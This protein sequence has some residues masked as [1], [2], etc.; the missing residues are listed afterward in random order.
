M[1]QGLLWK[2]S[3]YSYYS[4]SFSATSIVYQDTNILFINGVVFI[5]RLGLLAV[6]SIGKGVM[7]AFGLIRRSL[8]APVFICICILLFF[9]RSTIPDSLQL[10]S[11]PG[12][13]SEKHIT[14]SDTN[15]T[16]NMVK[17]NTT[18]TKDGNGNI[19]FVVRK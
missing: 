15:A 3:F 4:L 7:T 8:T 11:M 18:R 16:Q 13:V 9:K 6:T 10:L 2:L 14:V 17:V 5:Y 12:I 1:A 19:F